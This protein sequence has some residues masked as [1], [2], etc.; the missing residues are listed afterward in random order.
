M[1]FTIPPRIIPI[2]DQIDRFYGTEVRPREDRVKHRL[3][4]SRDYLDAQGRLHP[5]VWQARKEIMRRSAEAGLYSLH[6]PESIGGG[7]LNRTEML[8]VEEKVYSF[9]VG[10][11][12][13]ILSW[14]EGATP[15]LLYCTEDQRLRFVDPLVRGEK[16]C[17][18]GITEPQAG[19]NWFDFETR[20][21][22]DGDFWVLNG[23][24][25]F[26]TNAFEADIAHVVAVTDPGQGRRSFTY[27]QFETKEHLGRGFRTGEVYQTMWDDGFTGELFFEDLRLPGDAVIGERGGGFDIALASINWTRMRRGGMCSA[28]GKY[29]LDRT[30][31]RAK[32]R[33][34]G[35]RALGTRQG[36][37][38]MIADMYLD[39][40]Q[41]RATS[42]AIAHAIDAAGPMWKMPRLP[43]EIR[44]IAL[45]KLANDEAFY[46]IADRA[47]QI[48]GATGIMKDTT[49]NKLFLIA[50]NLRVPGG[51]DE[52]QRTTI[53]ETFGLKD[54]S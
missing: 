13:A 33:M 49:I 1:T 22:K 48:H 10:L 38:W 20:A 26:I 9:G 53:A 50:R 6:L 3:R 54:R 32:S 28:W 51:S 43:D 18:Q 24:K 44:Q 29:L 25:A 27:F 42:L 21:V 5:E 47:L 2:L 34:I 52:V 35:G 30:I 31:E 41:A 8:F 37:Q 12:P 36:I 40:Y 23:H 14:T 16:T 15:P 7:G 4:K 46:R 17:F 39:W 11:N 19:S 45:M